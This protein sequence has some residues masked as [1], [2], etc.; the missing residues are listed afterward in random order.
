MKKTTFI[1]IIA[2]LLLLV[3]CNVDSEH[4]IYYQV[5]TSQPSSGINII[6]SMGCYEF[7]N[8]FYHLFLSDNGICYTTSTRGDTKYVEE[9]K[10]KSIRGAYFVLS[11]NP[12]TDPSTIYFINSE[13][14][15]YTFS[16]GDIEVFDEDI[17]KGLTSNGYL[18][19]NSTVC[20]LPNIT[21]EA[22]ISL[23]TTPLANKEALLVMDGTTKADIFSSGVSTHQTITGFSANANG[24]VVEKSASNYFIFSEKSVYEVSTS[25]SATELGDALVSGLEAAP[26]GGY[27]AVH[28]YDTNAYTNYLLVRTSTG[29]TKINVD[30]KKIEEKNVQFL[31]TLNDVVVIDMYEVDG[32]IAIVT[33]ANGIRIADM[34]NKTLSEDIL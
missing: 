25:A 10:D 18:Y 4:G 34:V 7:D 20:R 24:F 12:S 3:S 33:Y 2:A 13:G 22:G 9:T 30:E 29:F 15:V 26:T 17:N 28:Y 11:E 21:S 32:K 14:K 16:G 31:S 5:A 1:T 8:V 6:Q 23:S 27:K 19:N